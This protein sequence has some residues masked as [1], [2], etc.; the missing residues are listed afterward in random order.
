MSDAFV[1][2]RQSHCARPPTC[3]AIGAAPDP[4]P[5]GA[6]TRRRA[7]VTRPTTRACA[8]ARPVSSFVPHSHRFDFIDTMADHLVS[9]IVGCSVDLVENERRSYGTHEKRNATSILGWQYF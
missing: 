5:G 4:W 3:D 8:A 1:S 6:I 2:G 9:E 7:G